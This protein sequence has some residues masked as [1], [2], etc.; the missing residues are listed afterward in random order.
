MR[1]YRTGRTLLCMLMLLCVI[2][3]GITQERT[4][5]ATPDTVTEQPFLKPFFLTR[6]GMA[7][8]R[9]AAWQQLRP[10]TYFQ[11]DTQNALIHRVSTMTLETTAEAFLMTA[12]LQ[13]LPPVS[14]T[15]Q[16]SGM[17]WDIYEISAP[18]TLTGS[19]ILLA[20]SDTDDDMLYLIVLQA[21]PDDF[22]DLRERVFYP[23]LQVFGQPLDDV[24]TAAGLPPMEQILLTDP[25]LAVVI[26][27]TWEPDADSSSLYRA[28]A[29]NET[30]IKPLLSVQSVPID[31]TDDE[32][33]SG[34][35]ALL[36]TEV[37][38]PA[39]TDNAL[40]H[41]G[42]YLAWTITQADDTNS[43]YFLAETITDS[44]RYQVLLRVPAD[45]A[46]HFYQQMLLPLLDAAYPIQG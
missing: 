18:D 25:G 1:I 8:L 12:G 5:E 16:R 13:D 2:P 29:D 3:A 7:G 43:I 37:T 28:P 17:T 15:L 24:Y 30:A 9:P 14:E 39:E 10:G 35:E 19:A 33:L 26:P 45:N 38:F 21:E 41:A 36:P 27:Q 6:G 31:A 40:S 42:A 4:P 32:V 23:A 22:N 44:Q 46:D 20:A 11:P 34:F